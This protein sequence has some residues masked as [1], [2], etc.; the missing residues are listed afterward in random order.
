MPNAF[1]RL[2][3]VELVGLNPNTFART[4]VSED[5]RS[6]SADQFS[7]EFQRE[8]TSDIVWRLGYVGTR[9]NDLFQTLDGNPRQPYSTV[10]VDPTLAVIRERSNTAT[11]TYHSLQTTLQ[12]RLRGG[13]AAEVHYTW[14]KFID[15]AS[16][17]FNPSSGEVA[18]PQDSFDIGNDKA[19]STYDRPHRFTGNFVYELPFFREQDSLDRQVPRRLAAELGV[20]VP[21]R[22][23]VHGAQRIGPDR[24]P[25][26][27]RRPRRQRDPV[28]RS[29][30]TWN[31]RR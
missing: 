1:V 17:I 22:R 29:T 3:D 25:G 31:C 16:E 15:T 18:V 28:R 19:V 8:L 9:G 20:H 12:K 26:R 24:R 2:P 30:R 23:A 13:F 21:E 14:S 27:H 10:R 4:I 11:S 5:F 6:P 7:L